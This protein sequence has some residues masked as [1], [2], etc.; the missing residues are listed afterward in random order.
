[1]WSRKAERRFNEWSLA[2]EKKKTRASE[3]AQDTEKC[4]RVWVFGLKEN[5]DLVLRFSLAMFCHCVFLH[6]HSP[7]HL[8]S[9][10]FSFAPLFGL[11]CFLYTYISSLRCVLIFFIWTEFKTNRKKINE[12]TRQKTDITQNNVHV[13]VCECVSCAH[14]HLRNHFYE[15]VS[16]RR[17]KKTH[18]KC[19]QFWPWK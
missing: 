14:G 17:R 3:R 6:T 8:F 16:N 11:W 12:G 4:V 5:D 10:S 1:M 19:D 7:F 2:S 9:L 15:G 13:C 18:K